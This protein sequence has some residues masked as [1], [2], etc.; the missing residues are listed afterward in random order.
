[1]KLHIN[2]VKNTLFK[3]GA[4]LIL[5]GILSA[6][7]AFAQRIEIVEVGLKLS[8][9]ERQSLHKLIDYEIKVYNG[10][11]NTWKNDSLRITINLYGKY[12]DF[13]NVRK[14]IGNYAPTDAGFYLAATNQSY[15]YADR[16][17]IQ[18]VLHEASH[19]LLR[20][21]LRVPQWMHEGIATFFGSLTMDGNQIYFTRESVYIDYVKTQIKDGKIDLNRF[22]TTDQALW[23]D[24]KNFQYLYGVSY[25]IIYYIIKSN[26]DAMNKIISLMQEKRYRADFAIASVF[27]GMSRFEQSYKFFYR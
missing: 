1:M 3:S 26:P 24:K 2:L 18:V 22:L 16:N 8:A 25:S 21:N 15:V 19:C 27:G 11:F 4:I 5:I 12:K 14:T 20:N 9:K 13:N 6:N 23:V 10:M 17:Y 7:R